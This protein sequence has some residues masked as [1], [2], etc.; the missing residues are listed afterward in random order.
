MVE[1]HNDGGEKE[2][3]RKPRSE[4]FYERPS[5]SDQRRRRRRRRRRHTDSLFCFWLICFRFL[6]PQMRFSTCPTIKRSSI[7]WR[8]WP[9]CSP[10]LRRARLMRGRV[11]KEPS[12][13]EP[14]EEP[15]R[16]RIGRHIIS[17]KVHQMKFLCLRNE[18]QKTWCR[19]KKRQAEDKQEQAPKPWRS[20]APT[21]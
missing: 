15:K 9:W 7:G 1:E 4:V 2:R 12:Y 17:K 13:Q 18:I 5:Y 16:Q 21:L 6:C 14:Q 11:Q 3:K 10:P 20:P 8:E 19:E